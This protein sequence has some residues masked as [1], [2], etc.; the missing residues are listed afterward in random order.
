MLLAATLSLSGPLIRP[1]QAVG[2]STHTVCPSGC[3][4]TTIQA[5][6]NAAA[7]GDT[8]QLL[9]TIPH[10]EVD[11]IISKDVTLEGVS[12]TES[13]VQAAPLPGSA[14]G[15]VFRVTG[16]VEVM[17]RDLTIRHGDTPLLGGGIYNDGGS[18]SLVNVSVT[19][20]QAAG[21]GGGISNTGMLTISSV[22]VE[23]N[24]GGD[25]GGVYNGGTLHIE[26]ANIV[27][28]QAREGGGLYNAGYA[29]ITDSQVFSNQASNGGMQTG[30]G[31][32]YNTGDLALH[33]SKIENNLAAV[34]PFESTSGGGGIYHLQGN[35]TLSGTEVLN[36]AVNGPGGGGLF[37]SGG[38]V[39]LSRSLIVL[40]GATVA[41][42]G[43][44]INGGS[45]MISRSTFLAN[46]AVSG[47][48]I[49]HRDGTLVLYA[50]TLNGNSAEIGGGLNISFATA[51][52]T[53]STISDNT[54]SL[55]GGGVYVSGIPAEVG[56]SNVTISDNTADQ[57]ADGDG[58]GGGVLA[59][60]GGVVNLK[61]SLIAGNHDLS[62][63][64]FARA[65]DCRGSLNSNGYNLIGTLGTALNGTHC[66]VTGNL[67]GN[68]IGVSADLGPLGDYGG[69]TLT[70]ALMTS[71]PAI[72]AGDPNGCQDYQSN[73]LEKDQ[74]DGLRVDRCDIGSFEHD[75]LVNHIYLPLLGND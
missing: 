41:G 6:V 20:N 62:P 44:N 26:D 35:L 51:D 59:E 58:Q 52:V 73:L 48:G 5:A 13:I 28:N 22:Q 53:N 71:S 24:S 49:F 69:L 14:P 21:D 32:I 42:G 60:P 46:Q 61:N 8:I 75:A 63:G 15:R 55:H 7:D 47:G 68:L 29:W 30:G 33:A 11:I 34:G 64:S 25:G 67:V 3:D 65:S 19:D 16:G 57:D 40:N 10:T 27:G 38:S 17:M 12:M 39:D 43:M 72:N 37:V 23:G 54:A 56:F 31:G 74:R 50:S 36:N 45:V 66:N 2:A 1:S 18:V 70:H 9:M 4:H